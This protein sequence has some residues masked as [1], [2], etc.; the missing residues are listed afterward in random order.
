MSLKREFHTFLKYPDGNVLGILVPQE[1]VDGKA[2]GET[3][4]IPY[5]IKHHVY[6]HVRGY[7]LRN[8]LRNTADGL[9]G[10]EETVTLF[11]GNATSIKCYIHVSIRLVMI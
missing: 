3:L 5:R 6:D 10:G 1:A 9:I 4:S 8:L 11:E 2:S 7:P